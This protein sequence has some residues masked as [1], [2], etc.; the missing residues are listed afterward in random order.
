VG[1]HHERWDGKGYPR[2]LA[3]EDIPLLGRILAVSDAY[4][5]MTSD[6]PYRKALSPAEAR[7]EMEQVAG[8]QLDPHLVQVFLEIVEKGG[9]EGE[10]GDEEFPV[11][12]AQGSAA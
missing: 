5:A 6:R 9:L 1:S 3:G 2:G 7:E 8:A 11:R 12:S 10:S 4:S